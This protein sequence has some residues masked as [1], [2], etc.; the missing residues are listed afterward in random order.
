[1]PIEITLPNGDVEIID[2]VQVGAGGGAV[3][4]VNGMTGDVILTSQNINEGAGQTIHQK[5]VATDAH[6]QSI[7]DEIADTNTDVVNLQ[8]KT[9][10]YSQSG[11]S[12]DVPLKDLSP[13]E[14]ILT[15]SYADTR[16]LT[17]GSNFANKFYKGGNAWTLRYPFNF[18]STRLKYLRFNGINNTPFS[19][20][21]QT[22]NDVILYGMNPA[23]MV[24]SI[25]GIAYDDINLRLTAYIINDVNNGEKIPLWHYN[26]ATSYIDFEDSFT[27]GIFVWNNTTKILTIQPDTGFKVI[28]GGADGSDSFLEMLEEIFVNDATMVEYDLVDVENDASMIA[29]GASQMVFDVE[30]KLPVFGNSA[31]IDHVKQEGVDMFIYTGPA[32]TDP[33]HTHCGPLNGQINPSVLADQDTG[34][35]KTTGDV[36]QVITTI[37]QSGGPIA[38]SMLTITR[39]QDKLFFYAID[40]YGEVLTT[41]A[42]VTET[43]IN[44]PWIHDADAAQ[45]INCQSIDGQ[46]DWIKL[47]SVTQDAGDST[48]FTLTNSQTD[49]PNNGTTV[50]VHAVGGTNPSPIRGIGYDQSGKIWF[51]KAEYPSILEWSVAIAEADATTKKINQE[52]VTN[53]TWDYIDD[54]I[55]DAND[56]TIFIANGTG[57]PESG[58][59]YQ[60]MATRAYDSGSIYMSAIDLGTYT[61]WLGITNSTTLQTPQWENQSVQVGWSD[62]V[63]KPT[64]FAPIIGTTATTAKAGDYNGNAPDYKELTYAYCHN[65]NDD[66]LKTDWS[67]WFKCS[68][69]GAALLIS[70]CPVTK[71]FTLFVET[72]DVASETCHQILKPISSTENDVFVRTYRGS[73]WTNWTNLNKPSKTQSQVISAVTANTLSIFLGGSETND[74]IVTTGIGD[75]D[76]GNPVDNLPYILIAYRKENN[77]I[78]TAVSQ[79]GQSFGAMLPVNSGTQIPTWVQGYNDTEWADI[80]NKPNYIAA[81]VTEAA[82]R[83]SIDAQ[84]TL[85]SAGNIKTINGNSILGTG[86]LDL[87]SGE[88]VTWADVTDKPAYIGAG[89]S[90]ATARSAIGA[91]TSNLEIGTTSTTA[92]RG[93]YAPT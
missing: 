19:N 3:S 5:F 53:V 6:L 23:G 55:T 51:L 73:T 37:D 81:G 8:N 9:A 10:I 31:N 59:E 46:L 24:M 64:T 89:V 16:Y 85:V 63:N 2:D 93:D 27:E 25:F 83:L 67:R 78:L 54:I 87:G 49:G 88:A 32:G 74:I 82:A 79:F 45:R 86:D 18:M 36:A 71:A 43:V 7:E 84:Q 57:L 61:T 4:S 20:I 30:E 21:N 13:T 33:S 22:T 41:W 12:I 69:D 62:V 52:M 92:K 44:N 58:H 75:S 48:I 68:T 50:I 72:T 91:G 70:N 47:T 34:W 60:V 90:Q 17:D 14:L 29:A 65:L 15:K 80:V 66:V 40:T 26:Q 38:N 42:D 39:Y 76:L 28:G 56:S 77:Y 35:V 11:S 1:M